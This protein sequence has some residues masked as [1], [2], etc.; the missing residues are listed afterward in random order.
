MMKKMAWFP[1]RVASE[2]RWY[3]H[4]KKWSQPRE[5]AYIPYGLW[6]QFILTLNEV[7][8]PGCS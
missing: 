6:G 3:L 1:L 7:S 5:N 8:G 4:R 2:S